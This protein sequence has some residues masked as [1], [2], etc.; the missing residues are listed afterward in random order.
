MSYA[1]RGLLSQKLWLLLVGSVLALTVMHGPA[2]W[3]VGT[4]HAGTTTGAGVTVS[5]LDNLANT[6]DT[7]SKG[8]VGK[9]LGIGLGLGGMLLMG[10]GRLG[11]GGLAAVAGLGAAFV[12]NVIGT[13]F[14]ATAAAPLTGLATGGA[15]TAW[16]A[17]A[18]GLLYPAMLALK[19]V[20]DPIVW[21]SL[22]LL[23]RVRA[24]RRRAPRLAL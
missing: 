24:Q 16:W 14:D 19:W 4:A 18:L 23:Q 9:M 6:V 22:A 10:G 17:P 21:V 20:L 13:A 15:L 1:K 2:A 11:I 7:Y 8:N 3:R 5:G 12:P